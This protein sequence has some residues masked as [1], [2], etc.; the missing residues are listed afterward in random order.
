MTGCRY[1]NKSGRLWHEVKRYYLEGGDQH[2]CG[3]AVMK[4]WT[5]CIS[6]W[7]WCIQDQIKLLM[8]A[9]WDSNSIHEP[10]VWVEKQLGR[11]WVGWCCDEAGLLVACVAG[12]AESPSYVMGCR[13]SK[14]LPEPPGDVQLDLVKKVSKT[15]YSIRY[16]STTSNK[17]TQPFL[18]TVRKLFTHWLFISFIL[19][20]CGT[21]L[22]WDEMLMLLMTRLKN[23]HC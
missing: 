18:K 15:P 13:N 1:F 7:I 4:L 20:S 2:V 12:W 21:A 11:R 22:H 3:I 8:P 17:L 5:F 19:H 23:G 6:G 10:S 9:D 16:S 14:V